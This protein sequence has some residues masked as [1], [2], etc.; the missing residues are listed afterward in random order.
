MLDPMDTVSD[1]PP[2]PAATRAVVEV[3]ADVTCPFAYV[4]LRRFVA[5]RA[6]HGSVRPRLRVRAWPLE[7]VNGA[8]LERGLVAR[9]VEELRVQVAPDLFRGF[10]PDVVPTSSM[11]AFE[12]AAAAYELGDDVGERISLAIREAFFE[13][14]LDIASPEV[15]GR[16]AAPDA[17]AVP[18]ADARRIVLNDYEEGTRRGVRGSPEFYLDGQGWYCPS[19]RI[20]K[21]DGAL[22]I[23]PDTEAVEAFLAACFA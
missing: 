13:D 8:P 12:L 7:L 5:R 22:S 3:F 1:L 15:L 10:D 18:D 6:E 2:T 20:K 4:G 19:L 16:I 17:I 9:H 21:V 14:A 23:E 11:P